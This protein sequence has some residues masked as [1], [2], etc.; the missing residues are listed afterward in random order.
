MNMRTVAVTGSTGFIG[1]ALVD[2]FL[3][4]DIQVRSLTRK[5][6][7][8]SSSLLSYVPFDLLAA[9]DLDIA[10]LEGCDCVVHL[11][12]H[13]PRDQSDPEEAE[14]CYRANAL[15]TLDLVMKAAAAGVPKLIQAVGANAYRPS[16]D[17][18][19]EQHQLYPVMRA[20]YYLASKIC[21]EIFA[22][23]W[24]ERTG[25]CI[26]SLRLSS[27]YGQGSYRGAIAEMT[28]SLLAG[29]VF[30]LANHGSFAADL[31]TVDDVAEAFTI[32][33]TKEIRGPINVG[34]GSRTSMLEAAH[35][36]VSAIGCSRALLNILPSTVYDPG[37]PALDIGRLRRLGFSPTPVAV[38]L[39][40]YVEWARE[41]LR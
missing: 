2:H 36:V 32:A 34:S 6:I 38:G 30:E 25:I 14:R 20:P 31:V 4:R 27:V 13:I 15:G 8:L 7:P 23:N 35:L 33:I 17:P 28:R 16:K 10:S 22:Q 21:Q 1:R 18:V 19:D 24:A 40:R 5:P 29:E 39:T 3:K 12:S 11:A 26:T 9:Q 37:F 41:H